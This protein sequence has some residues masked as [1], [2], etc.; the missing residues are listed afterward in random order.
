MLSNHRRTL[1]LSLLAAPGIA[2]LQGCGDDGTNLWEYVEAQPD[3]KTLAAAIRA[4]G[5]VDAVAAS[6]RT[7]FAPTDAAFE[8][9]LAELGTTADAL[10]G[11]TELLKAVL[12]YHLLGSSRTSADWVSGKAIEPVGGGFFKLETTGGVVLTDGRNRLA[13]ATQTDVLLDNGA[14]HR[15]DRVMLP[16][17]RTVVETAQNIAQTS[18]L[19]AAINAAGLAGALS[20]SGPFT[21]FAPVDTAFTALLTELG[22]TLDA[23]VADTALLTKVLTYH[24]VPARALKADIVPGQPITSLQGQSLIVDASLKITDA[25]QRV[26]TIVATDTLASNGVI[27]LIDRVLLPA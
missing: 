16:A 6:P 22:T 1:V 3:L 9:L 23:L 17:N 26:S 20:A 21:I 12:A 27:H 10:L 4:A 7:L 18:T 5:L 13:R 19:V 25:N 2:L 11:N 24:V 8:A 15:I 14:L